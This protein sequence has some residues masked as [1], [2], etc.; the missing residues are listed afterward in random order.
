MV[1]QTIDEIQTDIAQLTEQLEEVKAERV[2]RGLPAD[3]PPNYVSTAMAWHLYERCE[4]LYRFGIQYATLCDKANEIIE[5]PDAQKEWAKSFEKYTRLINYAEEMGV[6]TLAIALDGIIAA[7]E[8]RFN[9]E[10]VTQLLRLLHVSLQF[11]TGDY[12]RPTL[13]GIAWGAHVNTDEA[14]YRREVSQEY[15][16]LKDEVEFE[17]ELEKVNEHYYKIKEMI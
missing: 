8:N 10:S 15:L 4:P 16:R 5:L 1:S 7:I 14:T 6:R 13:D 12:S 17:K 3:L 11:I 9:Y 2:A